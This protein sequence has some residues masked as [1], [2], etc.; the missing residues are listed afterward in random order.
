LKEK[1]GHVSRGGKISKGKRDQKNGFGAKDL[2]VRGLLGGI[3]NPF[4][5]G[6]KVVRDQNP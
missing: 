5:D 4:L 2:W 1:N 6:E 3:K